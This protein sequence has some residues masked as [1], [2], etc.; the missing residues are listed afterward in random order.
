[1]W[2]GRG[3][4]RI[5]AKDHPEIEEA[6]RQNKAVEAEIRAM[7]QKIEEVEVKTRKTEEEIEEM[8][9]QRKANEADIR[10]MEEKKAKELQEFFVK[11]FAYPKDFVS[12]PL[13]SFAVCR[14]PNPPPRKPFTDWMMPKT[15]KLWENFEAEALELKAQFESFEQKGVVMDR[16][17]VPYSQQRY[18]DHEWKVH[19]FV[20][21]VLVSNAKFLESMLGDRVTNMRLATT[22]GSQGGLTNTV[23]MDATTK[24]RCT[25]TMTRPAY[26]FT[27]FNQPETTKESPMDVV[28]AAMNKC[29][30]IQEGRMKDSELSV[31]DYNVL[32]GISQLYT[33]LV[34]KGPVYA[35]VDA[36]SS[37]DPSRRRVGGV[38]GIL[39]NYVHWIFAKR[40]CDDGNSEVVHVSKAYHFTSARPWLLYILAVAM[41][42]N[43]K[44]VS[45]RGESTSF[46]LVVPPRNRKDNDDDRETSANDAA[47]G[48]G[49]ATAFFEV[50]TEVDGFVFTTVKNALGVPH[51]FDYP[52]QELISDNKF[53][54][55]YHGFVGE[56]HLVWRQL[57]VVGLPACEAD[58]SLDVLQAMVKKE[59]RA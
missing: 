37:E 14:D 6:E 17:E 49:R 41:V 2:G 26:V 19:Q 51:L 7:K 47:I 50:G 36:P 13:P 35:G 33:Y 58:Y 45:A 38:Y 30:E 1:M 27:D 11:N 34:T 43:A 20:D 23:V 12:M 52:N 3:R 32:Q 28:L 56:S 8:K 55:T 57:D 29:R 31:A 25:I 16:T 10:T 9:R 24:A 15:F 54:S 4:L 59:V 18:L 53:R 22:K 44:T 42:P 40:V 5:K 21:S 48:S 39:T 46:S